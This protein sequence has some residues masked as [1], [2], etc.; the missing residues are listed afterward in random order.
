MTSN[1][2]TQAVFTDIYFNGTWRGGFPE[3][4]SG[5]GSRLDNTEQLRA[6]LA[7]LLASGLLPANPTI[8]D[9]P[10]GDFNWFKEVRGYGKY[11]GMDIV[12]ELVAE[13]VRKYGS[14]SVTFACGDLTRDQ[15]PA[16]DLMVCKDCLIHLSNDMA[17]AVLGNFVRAGIPYLLLS[18]DCNDA[19]ADI[20]A[21]SYRQLNLARPPFNFPE[22]T[23]RIADHLGPYEK[24][25]CLW[26]A[27]Q[28]AQALA[29]HEESVAGQRSSE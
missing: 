20:P 6:G 27:V 28:V 8:L 23:L 26:T 5:A 16:A 25:M 19:N 1:K 18:S 2:P 29:N 21:G 3:T 24:Y 15:L 17:F 12:E 9:A 4:A 22:P 13:N 14:D 11:I 10:C 7:D